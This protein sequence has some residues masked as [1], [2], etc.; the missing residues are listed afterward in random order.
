[1][2]IPAKTRKPGTDVIHQLEPGA[3]VPGSTPRRYLTGSGYI[4]LRWKVGVAQYVE[5]YEHRVFDGFVTTAE[6]VHHVNEDKTD[7]R[8]ENLQRMSRYEHN[9]HHGGQAK[10]KWRPFRSESAALKAAHAENRR[11]DIAKRTARMREM[12]AVG[13]TTIQIGEAL[14]IHPSAVSRYLRRGKN[15]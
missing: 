5:T 11:F 2:T 6:H 1:M 9:T 14:G 4:R 15:W 13:L 10:S 12:S 8:P 7:N 3:R